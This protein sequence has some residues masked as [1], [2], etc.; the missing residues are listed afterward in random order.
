[1]SLSSIADH[2][3]SSEVPIQIPAATLKVDGG[4]CFF[5]IDTC[6]TG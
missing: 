6:T 4:T 2:P 1:M 3:Q 5:S